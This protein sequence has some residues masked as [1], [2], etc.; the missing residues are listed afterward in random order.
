[1][2]YNLSRNSKVFV[3]TNLSTAS[4]QTTV[5]SGT[6]N[7]AGEILAAGF[8]SNNC[9]EIQVLDGF[10]F[11]QGTANTSININEAGA[12]P[13]RGTR[14]FN[15]ALNPVEISFSTYIRPKVATGVVSADEKVLWNALLGSVG[16]EGTMQ[17]GT[18]LAA[19][20][21]GG[22]PVATLIRSTTSSPTFTITGTSLSTVTTGNIY[23][24]KGLTGID[25]YKYNQP[26]SVVSS[27]ATTLVGTYLTPPAASAATSVANVTVSAAAKLS[28]AAW[29]DVTTAT[30]AT[31]PFGL[32]TSAHSNKNKLQALGFIFNIDNAWYAIDNC[33]I[34]Q[35]SIDFGLDAI[36]TIAWSAK[37][38]LLKNIT[39]AVTYTSNTLSGGLTSSGAVGAPATT[40]QYITNKLS[41]IQLKS[42]L[43]GVGSGA[44][45]YTMALTGG[46][47]QIANNI[48][49][50]TPSNI[51]TLNVPI[52]YYTGNRAV[53]GTVNAYLR[54]GSSGVTDV[55]ALLSSMLSNLSTAT[56]TKYWMQLEIG[57]S[58][59]STKV[60]LEIP[61]ASIGVPSVD[62]QDVIS[63]AITLNAQGTAKD[64]IGTTNASYDIENTND[65]MI[66]YYA[67]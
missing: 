47:I 57:G 12:T 10:S 39:T 61:G 21:L 60:E 27:T 45:T 38:T 6:S 67:A 53:S 18:T 22:T 20:T 32:V 64:L 25:S 7:G 14:S 50:V 62:V 65:I 44:T 1:M 54:T 48:N 9:W 31:V 3:T 46:N 8:N 26:F 40:A 4:G 15:T 51:G 19:T 52:G 24:F 28:T 17:D 5:N 37:G 43:G 55:G 30:G 41:T 59:A 11:S 2:A 35:A 13:I 42:T 36:S 16:I 66:R 23:T 29:N 34:D 63:T 56:E 58:G 49:Y 33:A